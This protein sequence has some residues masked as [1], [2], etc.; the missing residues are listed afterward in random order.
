[1]I[2]DSGSVKFRCAVGLGAN[3]SRPSRG[4][5]GFLPCA[6]SSARRAVSR[7]A[8]LG[9]ERLLGLADLRQ[10]LLATLKLLRQLIAAT[11]R[12]EALILLRIDPLGLREQRVHVL[13]AARRSPPPAA[14]PS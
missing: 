6:S 3:G 10:P 5:R 8:R 14:A 2:F 13:R 4:A 12:P 11:V 9:L 7:L 1:M